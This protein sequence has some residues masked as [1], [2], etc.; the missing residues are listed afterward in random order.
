MVKWIYK[1]R[2]ILF[3]VLWI[4]G[5]LACST[6]I[7]Y[8]VSKYTMNSILREAIYSAVALIVSSLGFYFVWHYLMSKRFFDEI[9]SIEGVAQNLIESQITSIHS[10]YDEVD[11]ED[12]IAKAKNVIAIINYSDVFLGSYKNKILNKIQDESLDMTVIM[13]DFRSE[14]LMENASK[15]FS[16][17]SISHIKSKAKDFSI[18]LL[19]HKAK[20]YLASDFY[21]G[22]SYYVI[23][24]DVIIIPLNHQD[25]QDS[26]AFIVQAKKDS[27]FADYVL[28]EI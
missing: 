15:R 5:L 28:D 3:L 4:I 11:I 16:G 22:T 23:D 12:K 7:I 10:N 21:F 19:T 20:L 6:I 27:V 1:W 8:L 26:T 14:N 17:R 24:G 2:N 9:K 13:L 18:D 25:S